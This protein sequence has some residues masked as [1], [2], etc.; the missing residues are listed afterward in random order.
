MGKADFLEF[1][2]AEA[3][4]AEDVDT[5]ALCPFSA[6]ERRFVTEFSRF[7]IGILRKDKG[8]ADRD[9]PSGRSLQYPHPRQPSF[10]S[11]YATFGDDRF[12]QF[13]LLQIGQI[14][15]RRQADVGDLGVVQPERL[16]LSKM[17]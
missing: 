7:C 3:W 10:Q 11:R 17:L 2:A 1:G 4:Q 15:Q 16:E 14:M 8:A 9:S 6:C 5:V 13:E 12:H